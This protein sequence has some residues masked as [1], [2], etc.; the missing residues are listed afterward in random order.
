M[1]RYARSLVSIVVSAVLAALGGCAT[2]PSQ[3][4]AAEPQPK[5]VA[6]SQE[7]IA[8]I[9]EQADKSLAVGK[10]QDAY[11]QYGQVLK[12]EPANPRAMVG[13][14]ESYLMARNLD[15]ALAVFDQV[16]EKTTLK[17]RAQ[18]GRGLVHSLMGQ[19]DIALQLLRDATAEDPHL[20]RAWIGLG[21]IYDGAGDWESADACYQKAMALKPD[22]A[23]VH[24]NRGVSLMM[25]GRY[26]EASAA[27]ENALRLDSKLSLARAN[28]RIALAWQGKYSDALL[29]VHGADLP[30][31]LNNVGYVALMKGQHAEA[32]VYLARAVQASPSYYEKAV[33]NLEYVQHLRK[34]RETPSKRL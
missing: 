11:T 15:K 23:I 16:A 20:W 17:A 24:N 5:P 28:L 34:S 30:G 1:E 10:V 22:A 13:V 7:S 9:L 18:Q 33:R 8:L 2:A 32:E 26:D 12:H 4:Q 31:A 14:A 27:F 21:R 6:Y 29:G 19:D 25:R 3:R